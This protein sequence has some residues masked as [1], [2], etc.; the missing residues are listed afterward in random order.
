MAR[1]AS[2]L[3]GDDIAAVAAW[4]ASLPA[5]PD[6]PPAPARSLKL[7]MSCGSAP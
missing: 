7:P 4:L 6:T 5:S 2:R 3:S 1:I